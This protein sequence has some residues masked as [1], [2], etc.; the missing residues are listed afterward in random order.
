MRLV[1]RSG[2][3]VCVLRLV[4]IREIQSSC[5]HLCAPTRPE[6]RHS[7]PQHLPSASEGPRFV[8]RWRVS[9]LQ[10]LPPLVAFFP[11]MIVLRVGFGVH[12]RHGVAPFRLLSLRVSWDC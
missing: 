12:A 7:L 11:S 1:E 2:V 8:S 5:L 9:Q 10:G 3:V 6:E 4:T